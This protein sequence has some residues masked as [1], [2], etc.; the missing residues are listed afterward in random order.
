MCC[1]VATPNFWKA[2]NGCLQ[3]V[4]PIHMLCAPPVSMVALSIGKH[5]KVPIDIS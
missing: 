2:H 1:Q 4:D 3:L 5:I